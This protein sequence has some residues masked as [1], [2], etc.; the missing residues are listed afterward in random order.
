M[1]NAAMLRNVHTTL[2]SLFCT[3]TYVQLCLYKLVLDFASY[4]LGLS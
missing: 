4:H 1:M 3:Y 2:Q